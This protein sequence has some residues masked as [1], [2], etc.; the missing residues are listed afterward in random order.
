[1]AVR[2][3]SYLAQ[4]GMNTKQAGE[5]FYFLQKFIEA[6]SFHE[7]KTTSVYPSTRVSLRVPFGTG[8]AMTKL[9]SSNTEWPTTAF[10][11]FLEIKPLFAEM[12]YLRRL[13][14]DYDI[15][16]AK[17]LFLDSLHLQPGVI[18]FLA[19]VDFFE[20]VMSIIRQTTNEINFRKR[21]FRFFNLFMMIRYMH[22][23]ARN[24]H[25]DTNVFQPAVA[26]LTKLEVSFPLHSSM[27]ELLGKYRH[28]DQV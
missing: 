22:F 9:L 4:G 7:I 20:E 13:L 3:G 10:E 24:F 16:K 15:D 25:P 19:Q 6:G 5:D 18:S 2:R 17:S 26:L 14:I 21:V 11:V 12:G 8:K 28:L 23:A 27:Q 1:M